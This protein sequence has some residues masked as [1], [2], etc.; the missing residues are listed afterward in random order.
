MP[1]RLATAYAASSR[2]T[3]F[4]FGQ[5]IGLLQHVF[6]LF[7]RIQFL[8]SQVPRVPV[9][10]GT[11]FSRIEIRLPGQVEPGLTPKR[12]M[13][14]DATNYPNLLFRRIAERGTQAGRGLLDSSPAATWE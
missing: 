9:E 12:L 5:R 14:L 11:F 7:D 13:G 8:D 10:V 1:D 2:Q 3:V 4:K 6:K